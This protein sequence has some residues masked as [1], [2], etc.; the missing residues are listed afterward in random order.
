VTEACDSLLLRALHPRVD[1][2]PPSAEAC[3]AALRPGGAA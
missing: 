2:R 3:L 1:L